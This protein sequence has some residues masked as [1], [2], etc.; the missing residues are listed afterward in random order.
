MN[1]F[2]IHNY[3]KRLRDAL[4]ALQRS[5]MAEEDKETIRRFSE[6]LRVQ[7]LSLGRVAK[8]VYQLK[9]LSEIL[10]QVA[11]CR[12]LGQADAA[13]IGKL[14]LWLNE[15]GKYKPQTR[16][17]FIV[18]LKRFYQWLRAPL[19][20]YT[21]WRK[22]HLYPPKVE[23]LSSALKFSESVLPSGLL[24]E[25]EVGKLLSVANHPMLR[26]YISLSDEDA[27]YPSYHVCEEVPAEVQVV[28]QQNQVVV[29]GDVRSTGTGY[30]LLV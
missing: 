7:G 1:R 29:V 10:G 19:Q 15:S 12:S 24:T 18:V 13:A 5:Q 4:A 23:D 22:R 11:A 8:Y 14:S 30:Y 17:D 26:A 2:D 21:K 25:Q 3:E 20:E 28:V 27:G 6:L 9:T 16:K